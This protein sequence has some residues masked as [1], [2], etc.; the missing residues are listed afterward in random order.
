MD[1]ADDVEEFFRGLCDLKY[2]PL[3][4]RARGWVR[5]ELVEDGRIDP[6]LIAVNEGAIAVTHSDGP[7]ECTA[8]VGR[9][10]FMRICRGEVKQVVAVLRGAMEPGGDIELL[11]AIGRALPMCAQGRQPQGS[12]GES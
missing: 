5:Y 12:A 4:A 6:W 1:P 7:A 9:A 2:H 3:L 10:L 11:Q 8:R